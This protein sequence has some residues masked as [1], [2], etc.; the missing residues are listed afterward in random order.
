ML[1]STAGDRQEPSQVSLKRALKAIL[2]AFAVALVAQV[3]IEIA[4]ILDITGK[5]VRAGAETERHWG[6]RRRLI[7]NELLELAESIPQLIVQYS[8]ILALHSRDDFILHDSE[9]AVLLGSIS[10]SAA[11]STQGVVCAITM[12]CCKQRTPP[13]GGAGSSSPGEPPRCELAPQLVG[14]FGSPSTSR[15][16]SE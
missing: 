15:K 13:A 1:D 10:F 2:F 16:T 7:R 9:Y 4:I 11:L 8:L 3:Y 14:D 12:L 6:D 5:F